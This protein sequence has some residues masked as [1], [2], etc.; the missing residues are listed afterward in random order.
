MS[1][2]NKEAFNIKQIDNYNKNDI[3]K[4]EKTIIKLN[5][6]Y[7]ND[8]PLV[9]DE[10]Y[11][12]L[13][14]KLEKLSANSKV[15]KLVGHIPE[16]EPVSLPVWMGS[17]DKV[18][19]A[20][21]ALDKFINKNDDHHYTISEKLDGISLLLVKNANK[22]NCYTRGNGKIGQNVTRTILD[23]LVIPTNK[24]L[25]EIDNIIIRGEFIL[26]KSAAQALSTKKNLRS[27]VSGAVNAKIAKDEVLKLSKFIAYSLPLSHLTPRQQFHLLGE[28]G[29]NI[30]RIEII[31]EKL[32]TDYL[33]YKLVSWKEDSH[34][35]IDG[36]VI[37]KEK[38][39]VPIEGKNPKTAVAFKMSLESQERE[40]EVIDVEWNASK[41]GYLKPVVIVKPVNVDGCN[42]SRVTGNN[43]KFIITKKIGT[44]AKI[45]IIRSGDVIP[46]IAKVI[47]PWTSISV[48]DVN[49][50]WSKN[51]T[52]LIMDEPNIG[53]KELLYF[54]RTVSIKF[55]NVSMCQ[56]LVAAGIDSPEQLASV[57]KE[58]LLE[59]DGV[60]DK[61][62]T[63]IYKQI[64]NALNNVD[65][66]ELLVGLNKLGRNMGK[67]RLK[68]LVDKIGL[69]KFSEC[70]SDISVS[71]IKDIPGFSD[72]LAEQLSEGL[73]NVSEFLENSPTINE[74]FRRSIQKFSVTPKIVNNDKYKSLNIVFTGVRNK[75]L[76]ELIIAGGGK[77]LN[78]VNKTTTYLV[79][80]EN[81][82]K[83]GK[84]SSKEKKANELS[85][86]I[87]NVTE[88]KKI[89]ESLS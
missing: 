35:D 62:A 11:D 86:K 23:Y 20:T 26:P 7:T 27:I 3:N 59:L 87:I 34:Y 65:P 83:N 8:E 52:D 24:S 61:S 50:S 78:N 45:K 72:K 80:A 29:F 48:P 66:L 57:S 22:W 17:L 40:T 58:K 89:V 14:D 60:G 70:M 69:V 12:K 73:A 56:K 44:G 71:T 85:I 63:K 33:K 10:V 1:Q 88:F 2:E 84:I 64:N 16:K 75:E 31:N 19:P 82:N 28:Y 54:V 42:I 37:A 41:D 79:T 13:V 53:D 47:K 4:L 21:K 39:E 55:I 77:I 15:L 68:L 49:C 51:K 76:E 43:A 30:P 74:Y 18:K 81:V 9:T 46:K 38:Y 6:A 67:N 25:S 36:I 5:K 32:E